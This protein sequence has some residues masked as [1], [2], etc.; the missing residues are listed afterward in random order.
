MGQETIEIEVIDLYSIENSEKL[1]KEGVVRLATEKRTFRSDEILA[2][3]TSSK[4][5]LD[6]VPKGA[7]GNKKR[8]NL[9]FTKER[10]QPYLLKLPMAEIEALLSSDF[11]VYLSG[12]FLKVGVHLLV[13]SRYC[14]RPIEKDYKLWVDGIERPIRVSLAEMKSFNASWTKFRSD[15]TKSF[16]RLCM[17]LGEAYEKTLNELSQEVIEARDRW[18]YKVVNEMREGVEEYLAEKTK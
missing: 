4:Y 10:K 5:Q 11:G 17:E 14:N 12:T 18:M 15:S 3:T 2:I 7:K 8:Y 1:N 6:T 13:N 9:L 16:G